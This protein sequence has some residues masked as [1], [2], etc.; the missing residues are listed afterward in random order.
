MFSGRLRGSFYLTVYVVLLLS[1]TLFPFKFEFSQ[2]HFQE[3]VGQIQWHTP[4]MAPNHTFYRR[5]I[6]DYPVN[7]L[8]FFP[9]GLLGYR[10]FRRHPSVRLVLG[11]VAGGFLLSAGIEFSQLFTLTRFT[12]VADLVG[13][14]AGTALG[15]WFGVRTSR[16]GRVQKSV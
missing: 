9:I 4:I 7:I 3:R 16:S 14:T 15:V 2:R 12:S 5:S 11:I 13:N 10:S 1:A 6:A 8:L